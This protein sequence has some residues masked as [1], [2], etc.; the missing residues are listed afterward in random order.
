MLLMTP[1]ADQN[2]QVTRL[3]DI[4]MPPRNMWKLGELLKQIG[5]PYVVEE[6]KAMAQKAC[7]PIYNPA[8]QTFS[9]AW[10]NDPSLPE[11][12][13][14]AEWMEEESRSL[15]S[16]WS[17]SS[18]QPR[19]PQELT[20]FWNSSSLRW[21]SMVIHNVFRPDGKVDMKVGFHAAGALLYLWDRD[22]L[23]L[24]DGWPQELSDDAFIQFAETMNAEGMR[25]YLEEMNRGWSDVERK[26]WSPSWQAM[27][28]HKEI[29][30]SVS[31]QSGNQ[32]LS[33]GDQTSGDSKSGRRSL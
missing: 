26:K 13:N 31:E 5:K 24:S 32:S 23:R 18:S 12:V 9:F 15:S 1:H 7:S 28:E 25:L 21:E 14:K 16:S 3:K 27:L 20:W 17:G 4:E 33:D 30:E 11:T 10:E 8:T 29:S 19:T 6:I 22:I 2:W